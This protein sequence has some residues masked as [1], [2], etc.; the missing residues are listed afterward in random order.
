MS[1]FLPTVEQLAASVSRLDA[2]DW[3]VRCPDGVHLRSAVE[4]RQVLAG[5]AFPAAATYAAVRCA[6]ANAVRSPEGQ[7][8]PEIRIALTM[9]AMDMRAAAIAEGAEC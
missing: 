1:D 5:F 9:A 8:P 2:A 3:L 4:I 7:L 6:A